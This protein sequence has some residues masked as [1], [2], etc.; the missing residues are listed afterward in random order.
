MGTLTHK[1]TIFI[2]IEA[3]AFISY[4]QLLNRHLYEHFIYIGVYLL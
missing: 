4:K 2:R 3:Q 1:I